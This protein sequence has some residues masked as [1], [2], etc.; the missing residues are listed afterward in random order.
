M[1][2]IR[3]IKPTFPHSESLGRVT[4]DARLLFVSLWTVADDAGRTRAPSR[5]LASILFPYDKD[6][7]D[8]IEGWLAELET[9]GCIRR[10]VIADN[11]Y[12]DIPKWLDHQKIDHPSPSTLPPFP[13]D[14]REPSRE[15]RE[16]SRGPAR[17]SDGREGKKEKIPPG[18]LK[19]PGGRKEGKSEPMIFPL[20]KAGD[21][22][23]LTLSVIRLTAAQYDAVLRHCRFVVNSKRDWE[24]YNAWFETKAT[25]E[26][27][28][29]WERTLSDLLRERNHRN[30]PD[31]PENQGRSHDHYLYG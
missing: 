7:P 25:P 31:A 5:G 10:Y 4:R 24:D 1:A 2:R 30:D 23:A 18:A 11:H 12:L 15:F 17:V 28:E 16:P 29:N 9:V 21:P 19:A 6:A 20:A 13:G 8:L 14:P 27:R 22:M 26:Q 3:T